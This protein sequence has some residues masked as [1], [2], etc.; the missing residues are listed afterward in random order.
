MAVRTG[1]I[2]QGMLRCVSAEGI[3][4][5]VATDPNRP[6]ATEHNPTTGGIRIESYRNQAAAMQEAAALTERMTCKHLLY[7]TGLGGSKIIVCAPVHGLDRA[8]LLNAVAEVLETMA[9]RVYAGADLGVSREDMRYLADRSPYV[10][11]GIGSDVDPSIATA[12]GVYGV[13]LGTVGLDYIKNNR[14]FVHGMGK[15]GTAVAERLEAAGGEVL[16]YDALPERAERR[17]LRNVSGN[18]NWW[19]E[20]FDVLVPC[21][22]S[23]VVTVDIAKRLSCAH[24]IGSANKPFGDTP[25][26]VDVLVEREIVWVPDVVSNGA[27]VICDSME[28]HAPDSFRAA[29]GEA[30]YGCVSDLTA[31]LAERVLEQY[32]WGGGLAMNDVLASLAG[33]LPSGLVCGLAL[34]SAGATAGSVAQWRAQGA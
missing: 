5:F 10:L 28:Y 14:F 33:Q 23:N 26:V 29:Q 27:A 32:M 9:G 21:S 31:R 11:A 16:S 18:R 19:D 22:A 34:R 4:F 25:A 7:N 6:A 8:A 1:E 30:V 20:S 12:S 3:V 17:G 24:I 13:I 15:V 2:A